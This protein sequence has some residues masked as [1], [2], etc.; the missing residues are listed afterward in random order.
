MRD[1]K[2]FLQSVSVALN[3]APIC[4]WRNWYMLNNL[5]V[6]E[7]AK[8]CSTTDKSIPDGVKHTTK[9]ERVCVCTVCVS[10]RVCLW[11]NVCD[12]MHVSS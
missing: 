10:V 2:H 1:D 8:V 3:A 5:W 12:C 11:E 6:Q 9:A 7:A 4:L